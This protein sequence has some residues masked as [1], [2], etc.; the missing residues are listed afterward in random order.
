MVLFLK[1]NWRKITLIFITLFAIGPVL[2]PIFRALHLD[3]FADIFY[4]IYEFFCHQRPWRSYH[5]EDYQLA[6]CSRDFGIYLGFA[7]SSWYVYLKRFSRLSDKLTFLLFG[8]FLIPMGLDGGIQL[9]AEISAGQNLPFYESFN[10]LRSI[11]GIIVGLAMGLSL[12]SNIFDMQNGIILQGK[13]ALKNYLAK[14]AKLL[15]FSCLILIL[16]NVIFYTT[17]LKY[18]PSTIFADLAQR[19]PGLNYEINTNCGHCGENYNLRLIKELTQIY[20]SRFENS[21]ISTNLQSQ[22]LFNYDKYCK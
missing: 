16:S 15:V 11:T 19:Y 9:I 22:K 1:R 10:F 5:I 7:V 18:E 13:V 21:V 14:Y 2:A 20:C 3:L 6:V 12:I 17:S 4:T 8:F